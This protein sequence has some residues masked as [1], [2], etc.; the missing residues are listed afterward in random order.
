MWAVIR[1]PD[2]LSA[3]A[4]LNSR[5]PCPEDRE[6]SRCGAITT[7]LELATDVVQ[8]LLKGEIRPERM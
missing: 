1:P 7:T 8:V 4:A 3:E 6:L 2:L 5:P